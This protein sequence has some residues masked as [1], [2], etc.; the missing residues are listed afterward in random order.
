MNAARP[1]FQQNLSFIP[2]SNL[3]KLVLNRNSIYIYSFFFPYISNFQQLDQ[4]LIN[5]LRQFLISFVDNENFYKFVSKYKSN[6][7]DYDTKEKIFNFTYF[8]ILIDQI[9]S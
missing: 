4:Q 1:N 7:I 2:E 5:R 6:V 8:E 3:V 9:I